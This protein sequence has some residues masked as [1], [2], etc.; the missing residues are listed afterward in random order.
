[1]PRTVVA[2]SGGAVHVGLPEHAD[3]NGVER[4]AQ[5]ELAAVYPEA[6]PVGALPSVFESY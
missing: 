2:L 1:M 4:Q 6:I 5:F 3:A